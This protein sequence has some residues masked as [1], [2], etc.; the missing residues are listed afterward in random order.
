MTQ[1]YSKGLYA[2]PFRGLS[3]PADNVC[4]PKQPLQAASYYVE[5]LDTAFATANEVDVSVSR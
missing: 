5:A 1:R 4:F 3:L 2:Y